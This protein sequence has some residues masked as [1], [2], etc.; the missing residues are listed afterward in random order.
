[1]TVVVVV[2]VVRVAATCKQHIRTLVARSLRNSWMTSLHTA[3]LGLL[4]SRLSLWKRKERGI[5]K[6]TT[7]THTSS[8]HCRTHDLGPFTSPLL[9]SEAARD[10]LGVSCVTCCSILEPPKDGRLWWR[11]RRSSTFPTPPTFYSPPGPS[12]QTKRPKRKQCLPHLRDLEKYAGT[13]IPRKLP[14]KVTFSVRI[15]VRINPLLRC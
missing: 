6:S 12:G 5:H 2:V 7:H 13:T 1:M 4:Q 10:G 8:Q 3:E 14:L 9:S 11:R 15:L